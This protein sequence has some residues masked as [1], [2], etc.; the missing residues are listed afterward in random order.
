MTLTT[1]SEARAKAQANEL[2]MLGYVPT[3]AMEP[4]PGQFISINYAGGQEFEVRWLPAVSFERH[5]E[6]VRR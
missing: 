5:L 2:R 6:A 4:G 3:E 1:Q